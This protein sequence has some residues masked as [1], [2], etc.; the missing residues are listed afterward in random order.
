[1]NY[2]IDEK[3]IMTSA[4][5]DVATRRHHMV[6]GKSG[7]RWLYADEDNAASFIYV[8][9]GVGSDG[10]GGSTLTFQLVDGSEVKLK[11][12]WHSNSRALLADT[13]ID[14][15][16]SHRTFVVIGEGRSYESNPNNLYSSKTVIE[17]VFYKDDEPIIGSFDRGR[18][19]AQEIADEKGIRVF[20]YSRTNG[21][22]SCG[23]VYPSSWSKEDIQ[24]FNHPKI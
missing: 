10:F 9:G 15:R 16:N 2:T 13:G 1:M 21:G 24:N 5:G 17:N 20:C 11:G 22:S 18:Q 14:L 4:K 12:P 3:N 19:M 7:K 8:E 6:T 23:P